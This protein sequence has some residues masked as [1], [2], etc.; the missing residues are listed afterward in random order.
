MLVVAAGFPLLLAGG[1]ALLTVVIG[2]SCS[3]N[4]VG[5]AP[6]RVAVRDVPA[7]M[8]AIY[9][10]V[11]ARYKLP[12]EILAGIGK[13][14]CD[15]GLL[16]DPSCTPEPGAKGPGAANFAGASGPM[17][18]GIGGAAGDEYDA[19]RRFLRDPSLGP[20]DPTTAV[21][22]AS[23]VLIKDK[24]APTG[25]PIDAYLNYARAYNGAGPAADAYAARVIADA[26]A[27]QGAGTIAVG[28][29]CS[30]A[31]GTPIVPGSKARILADGV[32]AAPANAPPAVQA[33]IAAGNR[34]NH[35][36]YSYGGAHGDPAQ[37]MNQSNPN[38]AAVPGAEENGGPGYDC[39]SATSYVLWGG[40]LGQSLLAG[41]VDDSTALESVGDP[42]PGKWVT[43]Y[44]TAG[45]AYIEVAGIYFDTAA[46][47]GNPPNPPATGPRW[48]T[49]GTGP[50][51]FVARHPPGL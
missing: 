45:H 37:T 33:M 27:Y 21:E 28:G 51:G 12:W 30:A 9:Q 41:G 20:H 32:A 18:V 14:E 3:G 4:G 19:L 39:S 29:G 17:Q 2:Q 5:D 8:L 35:F 34:I 40:G 38:P 42:G 46:G 11:G 43:I 36:A 6:S 47:L 31:F 13:E 22:L 48:S 7:R 49:V 26:H 25:Q 24:G 16:P 1:A 15:H 10:Q 50:A 23:L 44:A